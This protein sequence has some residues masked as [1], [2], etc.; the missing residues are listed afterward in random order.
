M[1]HTLVYMAQGY[2]I[3]VALQMALWLV[4]LRTRDASTADIGWSAGMLILV[5]WLAAQLDGYWL[6]EVLIVAMIAV[7]SVRLSVYLAGRLLNDGKEDSRYARL[8][9]FWG[10]GAEKN[11]IIVFQLQPVFNVLLSVPLVIALQNPAPGISV[12]EWI[13]VGIW[14]AGLMWESVADHQLDTFRRDPRNRGRICSTGLW[15]Y[16]RHPNFF[17]EWTM[18]CAYAV[19]AFSSPHGVYGVIAPLFMLFLLM[20]VT[21]IPTMERHALR[22]KG[23][24]FKEYKRTTSFFVPMPSWLWQRLTGSRSGERKNHVKESPS[25]C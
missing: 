9:E 19:F 21:G 17:G 11:F 15:A 2:L 1:Q 7:W 18:W 8:R 24:A 3:L 4:Q 13:A 16:S 14:L 25:S 12:T 5:G 10:E 6:R 22:R 20:K 23:Q